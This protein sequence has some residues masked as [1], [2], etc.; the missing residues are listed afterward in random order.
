MLSS[1]REVG[2]PLMTMRQSTVFV[3]GDC[4][5]DFIRVGTV[6]FLYHLENV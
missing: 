6:H 5:R 1:G 3:A 2:L 4:L